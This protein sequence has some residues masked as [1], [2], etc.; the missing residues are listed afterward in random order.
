MKKQSKLEEELEQTIYGNR[1][2][3]LLESGNEFFQ[4]IFT[5][6]HFKKVSD[7]VASEF[8]V[9]SK[10]KDTEVIDLLMGD[11]GISNIHFEGMSDHE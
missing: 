3:V 2:L 1:M 7:A 6:E 10:D 8:Q 5:A 4:I 9:I 11:T